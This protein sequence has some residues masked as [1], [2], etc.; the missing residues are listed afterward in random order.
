MAGLR[1]GHG[2]SFLAPT[3]DSMVESVRSISW[4]GKGKVNRP[5]G[6]ICDRLAGTSSLA[7]KVN[8]WLTILLLPLPRR[9]GKAASP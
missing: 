9:W 1:C 7:R 3:A 2:M 5:A 8:K 6:M 4:S